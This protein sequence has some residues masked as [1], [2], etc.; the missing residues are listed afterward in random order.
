[1]NLELN[2]MK[3]QTTKAQ[4]TSLINEEYDKTPKLGMTEMEAAQRIQLLISEG[5]GLAKSARS[6]TNKKQ[7]GSLRSLG[8]TSLGDPIL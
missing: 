6:S 2:K 5:R 1:M 4:Q 3:A 7:N 8:I